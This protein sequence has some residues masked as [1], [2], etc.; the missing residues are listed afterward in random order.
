[1]LNK[2]VHYDHKLIWQSVVKGTSNMYYD[3]L[4]DVKNLCWLSV[5]VNIH[6]PCINKCENLVRIFHSYNSHGQTVCLCLHKYITYC[7]NSTRIAA[8]LPLPVIV[9]SDQPYSLCSIHSASMITQATLLRS[10]LQPTSCTNLRLESACSSGWMYM[11]CLALPILPPI[12]YCTKL[13]LAWSSGWMYIVNAL[14]CLAYRV[15]PL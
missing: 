6:W 14:P 10:P 3:V 13:E 8:F 5:W 11:R 1:M 15:E 12:T 9:F 2:L 7:T 4:Y